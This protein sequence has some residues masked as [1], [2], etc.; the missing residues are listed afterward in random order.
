[1]AKT[2]TIQNRVIRFPTSA[3]SPNWAPAIV[4]FAEAVEDAL[5]SIAGQFDVPPQVFNIDLYNGVGTQIPALEFPPSDV[6]HAKIQYSVLRTTDS[7]IATEGGTI[8]IFYNEAKTVGNKWELVVTR[9]GDALIDFS[10][11]SS[12]LISFDTTALTGSNYSGFIS[13]R[14]LTITNS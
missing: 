10:I 14:A 11:S 6:I 4:Q 2:I 1:M 12:G 8:E 7:A 13:F 3:E 5:N 9:E